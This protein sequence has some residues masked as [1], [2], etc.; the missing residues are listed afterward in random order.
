MSPRSGYLILFFLFSI[1]KPT[2]MTYRQVSGDEEVKQY[3][4]LPLA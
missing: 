4:F 3:R 1:K 2:G